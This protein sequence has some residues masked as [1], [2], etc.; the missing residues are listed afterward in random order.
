MKVPPDVKKFFENFGCKCFITLPSREIGEF[1][2]KETAF[3]EHFTWEKQRILEI[4]CG[5][6][7]LMKIIARRATHVVGID[8]SPMQLTKAELYLEG[9]DNVA[10]F[11]MDAD[12]LGL[13]E[14]RF[15]T[16]VCLNSSLSNMPGIETTVIAEMKR[17]TK[18]G[19]K[20]ILTVLAE[21]A[22]K[23]QIA[24]YQRLGLSIANVDNNCIIT[25]EGLYSRRF[26]E[27][28]LH[29]IMRGAGVVDYTI[30]RFCTIG[31]LVLAEK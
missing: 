17:V 29:Q 15:D 21:N 11:S 6:G 5:Y 10:Y 13:E 3:V 16:T 8:F 1:L 26:S 14:N 2:E 27:D 20:I 31:Y 4:G 22:E 25:A 7:R 12:N 23:A 24:N 18:P 9:L 30:E 28:D 19:G